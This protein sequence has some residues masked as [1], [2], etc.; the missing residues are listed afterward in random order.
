MMNPPKKIALYLLLPM[1]FYS[2][3]ITENDELREFNFNFDSNQITK[4]IF[5]ELKTISIKRDIEIIQSSNS[6]KEEI[7]K[8]GFLAA[9]YFNNKFSKNKKRLYFVDVEEKIKTCRNPSKSR[10]ITL[11]LESA[12]NKN[13]LEKC[14]FKKSSTFVIKLD[15]STSVSGYREITPDH[16]FFEDLR[17]TNIL[18]KNK[19]I[20]VSLEVDEIEKFVNFAKQNNLEIQEKN[21]FLLEKTMISSQQSPRFLNKIKVML[22]KER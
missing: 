1:L 12:L 10:S 13:L 18:K 19:F 2:C 6:Q 16:S 8:K 11:I 17:I 5:N 22:G 9:F 21:L 3:A 7:F 20:L 15:K 14:D 4:K